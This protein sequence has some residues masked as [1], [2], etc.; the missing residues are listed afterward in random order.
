MPLITQRQHAGWRRS[1]RRLA[2]VHALHAFWRVLD[3]L[4]LDSTIIAHFIDGLFLGAKDN[5]QLKAAHVKAGNRYLI[6][7]TVTKTNTNQL[8]TN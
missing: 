3:G 8:M 1:Q 7:K 2:F 4:L 6:C 5:V